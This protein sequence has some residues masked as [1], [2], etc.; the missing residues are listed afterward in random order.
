MLH[1]LVPPPVQAGQTALMLAASQG[2]VNMVKALLA[3]EADVNMQDDNGSTA[4]MCACAHGHKE[5]TGLLLAVP[6]CDISLTDRVSPCPV[7]L[8]EGGKQ[9]WVYSQQRMLYRT[10]AQL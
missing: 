8:W 10:G 6:S 3:C 4:L 2:R 9:Y 7:H 5:I 1:E